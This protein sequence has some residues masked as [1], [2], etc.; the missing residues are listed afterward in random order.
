MEQG[1]DIISISWTTKKEDEKLKEEIKKAV[2]GSGPS[3]KRAL[4]FCSV[5][6]EGNYSGDIF[7]VQWHKD[8]ILS[9]AATDTYGHLTPASKRAGG[10]VSIQVPGESIAAEGPSYRDA[11]S[12]KTNL[13]GSTPVSGSSVATALAAG[14]RRPIILSCSSTG[15]L[16]HGDLQCEEFRAERHALIRWF[17]RFVRSFKS[18]AR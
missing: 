4:V 13:D 14:V 9:V 8:D 3:G 18:D 5:A 16:G 1:V 7:P 15:L 2:S 11:D 17:K 12:S 10:E 6:D